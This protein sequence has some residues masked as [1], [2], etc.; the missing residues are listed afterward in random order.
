MNLKVT[1]VIWREEKSYV[2]HCPE[3]GVA[4]CGRTPKEALDNLK[5]AVELYLENAKEL[6]LLDEIV[7]RLSSEESYTAFIEVSV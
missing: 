2:S 1:S 5:E 6:G 4:S 7:S 3:L